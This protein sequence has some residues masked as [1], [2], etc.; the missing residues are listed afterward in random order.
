MIDWLIDW[1]V[2][3]LIGRLLV[4]YGFGS[5]DFFIL[6]FTC[7]CVD[8]GF[9]G[10]FCEHEIDDCASSPC[11]HNGTC[12]D[13]GK[14][15]RCRCFD[16]YLGKNCEVDIDECME[17]APPCHN[18]ATCYERSNISLYIDRT[19]LGLDRAFSYE[20]SAGYVCVCLPGFKGK[21]CD[22]E[23]DECDPSPCVHGTCADLVNAYQCSCMEGWEGRN[24][25]RDVD[26]CQL[27]GPCSQ[28]G[29]CENTPGSFNCKCDA[30]FGGGNCSVALTG[31][32]EEVCP[33]GAQCPSFAKCEWN[34][35][36]GNILPSVFLEITCG[37][38]Y[39]ERLTIHL[40]MREDTF[41]FSGTSKRLI[42]RGFGRFRNAFWKEHYSYAKD[43]HLTC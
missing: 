8:T 14:D 4:K 33:D 39:F 41:F 21:N 10:R 3:W 29:R 38:I 16:G 22:E 7:N 37:Q 25:E 2:D 32:D 17:P 27:Y 19:L 18:N 9:S 26:E 11:Q 12:K 40:Q 1:S 15:Y 20:H 23:I 34:R 36:I 35:G 28:H 6:S 5:W 43:S 30:G 31:C 24:C 42:I 13:I